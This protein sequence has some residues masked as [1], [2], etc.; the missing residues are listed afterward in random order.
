MNPTGSLQ[1]ADVKNRARKASGIG[2][3]I[4]EAATLT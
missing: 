2:R 3:N 1:D 4:P